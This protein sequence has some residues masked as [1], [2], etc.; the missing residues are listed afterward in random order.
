MKCDR[1]RVLLPEHMQRNRQPTKL[2]LGGARLHTPEL[3]LEE[4]EDIEWI[5]RGRDSREAKPLIISRRIGAAG[6]YS[7]TSCAAEDRK[8]RGRAMGRRGEGEE[9]GCAG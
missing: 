8:A 1:V 7:L 2:H 5:R 4:R 6:T 9:S 3:D